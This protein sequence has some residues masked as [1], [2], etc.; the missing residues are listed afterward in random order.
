MTPFHYQEFYRTANKFTNMRFLAEYMKGKSRVRLLLI[1]RMVP[2]FVNECNKDFMNHMQKKSVE[3]LVGL[4]RSEWCFLSTTS[5]GYNTDISSN[6]ERKKL[7][8]VQV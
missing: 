6:K 5:K 2:K 4:S 1:S 8:S 7:S 3:Y